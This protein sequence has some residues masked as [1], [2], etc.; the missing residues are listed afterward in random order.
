MEEIAV[1]PDWLLQPTSRM[2]FVCGR[3]NPVGLHLQL[4][5]DHEAGEVVVPVV[6]PEAYQGYPGIVH[7]GILATILDEVTGRAIMMEVSHDYFWVTA[8]M[9]VRY[10]KPT[11]TGTSLLVAGWVVERRGR[12][13]RVAG[14]IRLADGV[15]TVESESLVVQPAEGAL[16]G[17][18]EEQQY[19]R[20]ES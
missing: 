15:V 7:G 2:C 10:R 9:T 14:E 16:Q 20:V 5:E 3:D 18:G 8:K 11:P 6:I 4:Y 19:W 17:W 12:S 13:A 1:S